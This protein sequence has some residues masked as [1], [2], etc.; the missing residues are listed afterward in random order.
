MLSKPHCLSPELTPHNVL[1]S[2]VYAL[3]CDKSSLQAWRAHGSGWVRMVWRQHF[4]APSSLHSPSF[5]WSAEESSWG[6]TTGQ[7]S[8]TTSY[9]NRLSLTESY[10]SHSS[11]T[12]LTRAKESL[13]KERSPFHNQGTINRAE[14]T[15][16]PCM[17]IFLWKGTQDPW[18]KSDVLSAGTCRQDGG[19]HLSFL[20][21]DPASSSWIMIDDWHHLLRRENKQSTG[22]QL[23]RMGLSSLRQE[24]QQ[25]PTGS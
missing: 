20:P 7:G 9:H 10:P 24:P 11:C 15:G 2:P 5:S 18:P 3:C 22:K 13:G 25:R 19:R 1:P 23:T 14:L 6:R 21:R 17:Y 4:L 16:F 12:V 8:L